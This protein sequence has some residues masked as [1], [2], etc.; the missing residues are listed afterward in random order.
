[1]EPMDHRTD[2]KGT[3]CV[4]GAGGYMG[5]WLVRSLLQ[6]G[7]KV[8]AATRDPEKASEITS[9]DDEGRLKIFKADMLEQG[10]Y[11][12]AVQG[13]RGVFH[14]AEPMEFAAPN[15]QNPD[16]YLKTNV[17]KLASSGT[18]N[19]LEAAWKAKSVKRVV[20]TSSLSIISA[21]D[22]EGNI[23]AAMVDES[24]LNS[25]DAVIKS[26]AYGWVYVAS[27]LVADQT[28]WRFAKEKELDMVSLVPALAAGLPFFTPTVPPALQVLLSPI[29][30]TSNSK[31]P[32]PIRLERD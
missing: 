18:L 29:T 24:C 21:R 1:M 4:T 10:S 28:A 17:H 15:G 6:K 19:V 20:F 23:K 27:E 16:S 12:A 2:Q 22:N 8:H 32:K 3:F 13:C 11:D 31:M 7:Y 14:V 5:S 30:G 9:F 26:R 25:I